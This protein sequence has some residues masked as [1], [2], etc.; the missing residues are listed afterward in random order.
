MLFRSELVNYV[1]NVFKNC[2]LLPTTLDM[3]SSLHADQET[4][5]DTMAKEIADDVAA[6]PD[7][8]TLL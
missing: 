2:E 7:P 5:I 6:Y 3:K 8:N 1:E 4:V